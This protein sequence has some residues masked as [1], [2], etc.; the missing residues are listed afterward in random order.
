[1]VIVAGHL[2]V[3]PAQRKSYLGDCTRVVEQARQAPGCLD[4]V[5]G[6]DLLDPARITS[7]SVGSRRPPSRRSAV[8]APA[9]ISVPRCWLPP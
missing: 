8:A 5:I 6:A 3:V 1:M 7:S 2:V 4:F 9:T